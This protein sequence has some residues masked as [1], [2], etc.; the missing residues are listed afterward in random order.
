[1]KRFKG[2]PAMDRLEKEKAPPV[3][4]AFFGRKYRAD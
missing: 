2:A 4:A 3:R 1:M